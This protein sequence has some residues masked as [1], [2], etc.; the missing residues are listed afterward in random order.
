[1]T[2][3]GRMSTVFTPGPVHTDNQFQYMII[4][5]FGTELVQEEGVVK[6]SGSCVPR[7]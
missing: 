4:R 2:Y 5:N 1:M 7:T 3:K 6:G